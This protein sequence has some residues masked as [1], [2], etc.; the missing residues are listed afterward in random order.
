MAV[1]TRGESGIRV[2]QT[3]STLTPIFS[4]YRAGAET[5]IEGNGRLVA[6]PHR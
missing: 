4:L 6:Y 1:P 5:I 3:G 2:G